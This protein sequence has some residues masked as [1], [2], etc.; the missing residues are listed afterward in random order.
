[1]YLV[2]KVDGYRFY[3]NGD[4]NSYIN[5]YMDTLEKSELTASIRIAKILKL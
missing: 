4:I 5:C 1:M 3:R 2:A